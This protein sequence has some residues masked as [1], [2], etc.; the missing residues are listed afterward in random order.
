M[1]SRR[2]TP[3][4]SLARSVT[5]AIRIVAVTGLCLWTLA[6]HAV[7]GPVEATA[8]QGLLC[9]QAIQQAELG[10][11]LP[12]H[13]LSGIARVESGRPDPVTGRIHPWPWTINAEGQGR[14]FDSKSEAI[15]FARQLQSRGV[16]SMDVGCLQVNLM[17]HPDAFT[18]LEEAFDP[19]VNARFAVKFLTQLR[20]KTGSWEAASAWYH[21]ATPE[22]GNPYRERV[23]TA[24]AEEANG[25]AY[26]GSAELPR[27]GWPVAAAALPSMVAGNARIILLP[28]PTTITSPAQ[29][30]TMLASATL[31]STNLSG[32]GRG[33][34]VSGTAMSA[35][36]TGARSVVG[37]GL[38]AYRMRPVAV[39][40]TRLIAAR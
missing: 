28:R 11:G 7:P 29:T 18:S 20:D 35:P 10:S 17:H 40:A 31:A 38:A 26:G 37:L 5:T 14:F 13:L 19:D 24:M 2:D 23:V 34:P 25:S 4:S 3:P 21:S 36:Q 33:G 8:E 6:A 16:L 30:N 15:A 1:R 39:M 32:M 22:L 12:P 9:R 27:A